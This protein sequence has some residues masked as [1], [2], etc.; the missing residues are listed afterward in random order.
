LGAYFAESYQGLCEPR[1]L[2]AGE[3]VEKEGQISR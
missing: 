2:L 3:A 1:R